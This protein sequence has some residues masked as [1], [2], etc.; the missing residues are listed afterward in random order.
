MKGKVLGRFFY[1]KYV[2]ISKILNFVSQLSI[3]TDLTSYCIRMVSILDFLDEILQVTIRLMNICSL[4]NSHPGILPKAL[5]VV[6]REQCKLLRHGLV[7][8][9]SLNLAFTRE[10]NY[11][12]S[13]Q[14]E[15]LLWDPSRKIVGFLLEVSL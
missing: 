14:I 10:T 15:I 1:L 5:M 4:V 2:F 8:S 6:Q 11:D 13:E 7:T 12:D 9:I 3:P